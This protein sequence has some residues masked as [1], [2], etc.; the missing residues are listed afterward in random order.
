MQV[1][2]NNRFPGFGDCQQSGMSCNVPPVEYVPYQCMESSLNGFKSCCNMTCPINC[3]VFEFM[4]SM[5]IVHDHL[6]EVLK[7]K[8][9]K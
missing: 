8:A 5:V 9:I 7:N 2:L 6:F 4:H 1:N 3:P